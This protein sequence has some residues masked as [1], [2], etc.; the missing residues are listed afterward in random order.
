MELL[1]EL[2]I[3]EVWISTEHS[4]TSSVFATLR[5]SARLKKDIRVHF[6]DRTEGPYMH[7]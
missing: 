4:Q 6:N 2:G 3:F 5:K 7:H 1:V